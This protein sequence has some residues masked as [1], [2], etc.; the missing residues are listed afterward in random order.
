VFSLINKKKQKVFFLTDKQIIEYFNRS[1]KAADGLWF[2]KVEEKY[3]FDSA[4]E[5]DKKVWAIVPKIQAR[6]IKTM[7]TLGNT[8]ADLLVSLESK[9]S[10]EGFKYK[11]K[12]R[13]SGF[14]IQ[15]CECP[16]H[17]MMIK[18]GREKYSGKVGSEICSIEYSV[19]I[20]EFDKNIQIKIQTK[21]CQGSNFCNL[22]FKK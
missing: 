18:S 10:M 8:E 15:I 12:K 13:K 3:G 11:V 7:L 19:W 4:L 14:Q 22:D 16:W 9:L 20:H 17:N 5:I 6:M 2:M 21:K 1:F